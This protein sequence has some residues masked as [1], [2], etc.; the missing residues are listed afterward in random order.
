MGFVAVSDNFF[1]CQ[2]Y[3]SVY[4]LTLNGE[5]TA[6]LPLT[7]CTGFVRLLTLLLERA[8]R[9]AAIESHFSCHVRSFDVTCHVLSNPH[10][11]GV[12]PACSSN[13]VLSFC[14]S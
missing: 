7:H 4:V 10:V 1:V 2:Q 6:D 5:P 13:M 3:I 9:V 12:L 14:K 11:E 8:L